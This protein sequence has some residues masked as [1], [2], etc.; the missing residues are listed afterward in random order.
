M[1]TLKDLQQ[2]TTELSKKITFNTENLYQH[3]IMVRFNDGNRKACAIIINSDN[4]DYTS[5]RSRFVEY[6][7]K[8]HSSDNG[9]ATG[10]LKNLLPCDG[11]YKN[12]SGNWYYPK[13][14]YYSTDDNALR[15]LGLPANTLSYAANPNGLAVLSEYGTTFTVND[16]V[17]TIALNNVNKPSYKTVSTKLS[18]GGTAETSANVNWTCYKYPLGDGKFKY[19]WVGNYRQTKSVAITTIY[20][21]LFMSAKFSIALPDSNMVGKCIVTGSQ[22]SSTEW[23]VPSI[24]GTSLDFYMLSATS[25]T[26]NNTLELNITCSYVGN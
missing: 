8:V 25:A 13:F 18:L 26:I 6:M 21:S 17:T 15:V 24:G 5:S 19:E 3:N 11:Y 4:M 2:Y 14:L 20:G 12:A 1:L 16:Y 22:L 10:N 7:K 23:I 9:N